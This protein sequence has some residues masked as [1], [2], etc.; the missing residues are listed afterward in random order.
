VDSQLA[1]HRASGRAAPLDRETKVLPPVRKCHV[2]SKSRN[3]QQR[4]ILYGRVSA[5]MGRGDDLT[6]P[7]LQE[8][9]VRNYCSR[10]GYEPVEW[11]CDIDLS[12]ASWSRRQ[13]E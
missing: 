3:K 7:E 1:S 8:H 11:L 2:D 6:S 5:V 12:G 10:R 9:V 4:A 13:V